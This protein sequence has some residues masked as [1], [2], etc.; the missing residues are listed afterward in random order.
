MEMAL[1]VIDYSNKMLQYSGA[2]C[3]LYFIRNKELN[4][5]KGDYMPI[6][7]HDDDENSF[8]NKELHFKEDDIIYLF[9]DGY[10]SQIG[11]PNRKTFRSRKFK[12]LLINIHRKP[13]SEQKEIL[14]KEYEE[15][16][17]DIEQIDDIMVM[18]I[19]FTKV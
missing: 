10:V 9:S 11:G 6:G 19:S 16:R 7:I 8:S 12:Q 2:F 13:L 1:C 4:E 17:H 15:W 5:I 14:E 3:P 18:G